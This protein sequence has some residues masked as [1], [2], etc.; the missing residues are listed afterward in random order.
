MKGFLNNPGGR[1]AYIIQKSPSF[2]GPPN[3]PIDTGLAAVGIV[4]NSPT[5]HQFFQVTQSILDAMDPALAS[6]TNGMIDKVKAGQRDVF[7]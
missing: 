5:Y 4:K 3:Y 7:C 6:H 2:N 1:T